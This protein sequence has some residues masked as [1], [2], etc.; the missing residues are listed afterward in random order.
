MLRSRRRWGALRS[1]DELRSWSTIIPLSPPGLALG[2]LDKSHADHLFDSKDDCPLFSI[3][4]AP[5]WDNVGIGMPCALDPDTQVFDVRPSAC[6]LRPCATE[7]ELIRQF[8][9]SF[10]VNF[11]QV[12]RW[13]LVRFSTYAS[14][15]YRCSSA[16]RNNKLPPNIRSASTFLRNVDSIS[17]RGA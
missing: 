16:R 15:V 5:Q 12:R 4:L 7:V 17:L 10:L 9:P 6:N 1:I 3:I 2:G 13:F 14:A 11:F 8:T